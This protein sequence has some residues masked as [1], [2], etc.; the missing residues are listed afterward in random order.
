MTERTQIGWGLVLVFAVVASA[1]SVVT[2]RQLNRVSFYQAQKLQHQRDDLSIEWRQLMA[3]YSTWRL[4]HKV[5]N[6]VRGESGLNPPQDEE[7]K[8]IQL[9]KSFN[10]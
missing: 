5:E 6:E 7:I 10:P 8:T 4:E 9:A 2:V 1:L 3:E